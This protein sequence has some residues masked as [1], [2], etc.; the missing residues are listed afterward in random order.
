[1]GISHFYNITLNA[2]NT[3]DTNTIEYVGKTY[4]NVFSQSPRGQ[5]F[6]FPTFHVYV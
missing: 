1:M 2:F 5:I 4:Y 3:A 6:G